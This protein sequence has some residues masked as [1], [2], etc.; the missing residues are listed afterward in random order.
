MYIDRG[1]QC[2]KLGSHLTWTR[3]EDFDFIQIPDSQ[4]SGPQTPGEYGITWKGKEM[5]CF[6]FIDRK[7]DARTVRE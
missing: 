5:G 1:Y 4:I 3:D 7:E 6:P 2:I